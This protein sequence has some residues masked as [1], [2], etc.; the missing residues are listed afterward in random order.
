MPRIFS[1]FWIGEKKTF[2]VH[3]RELKFVTYLDTYVLMYGAYPLKAF[4]PLFSILS[5]TVVSPP[6]F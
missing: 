2:L 6:P 1:V 5:L 4:R 3:E